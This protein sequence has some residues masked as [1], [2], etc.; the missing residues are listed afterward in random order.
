MVPVSAMGVQAKMPEDVSK[1][2]RRELGHYMLG[3]S[4]FS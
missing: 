1:I 2:A 4:D 3:G